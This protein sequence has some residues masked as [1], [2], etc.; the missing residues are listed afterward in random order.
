MGIPL[1]TPEPSDNFREIIRFLREENEAYRTASREE[2]EAARTLL[3]HSIRIISYPVT[4]AIAIFAGL[5]A[6]AGWMGLRS[7]NEM[8]T[9]M[10]IEAEQ[11]TRAEVKR[12]QQRIDDQLSQEFQDTNIQSLIREAAR[13]ATATEAQPLIKTEV[14]RQVAI[15]KNAIGAA[16]SKQL[17]SESNRIRDFRANLRIAVSSTL[18]NPGRFSNTLPSVYLT[19][20]GSHVA[21]FGMSKRPTL[22]SDGTTVLGFMH[23]GELYP[24]FQDALQNKRI[25]TLNGINKLSLIFV[26]PSSADELNNL[27][28]FVKGIESVRVELVLNGVPFHQVKIDKS[29]LTV[30]TDPKSLVAG[31]IASYVVEIELDPSLFRNSEAEYKQASTT[32]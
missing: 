23:Q 11:A 27:M 22:L 31:N 6:L 32:K 20:K 8:K 19:R 26:V 30:P 12:M 7:F 29:K 10:R 18:S 5:L 1:N 25:N 14:S 28:E 16:V 17:E 24:P 15:E 9:S 21:E 3:T 2:A 4:A 13:E